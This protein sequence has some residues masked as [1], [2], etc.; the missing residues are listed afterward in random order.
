MTDDRPWWPSSYDLPAFRVKRRTY[1]QAVGGDWVRGSSV[2]TLPHTALRY[3]STAEVDSDTFSK[4]ILFCRPASHDTVEILW[5]WPTQ[6]PTW[7]EVALVRSSFG[8]PSTPRDGLTVFRA[9]RED[10]ESEIEGSEVLTPPPVVLDRMMPSKLPNGGSGLVPNGRNFYYTLFF[11]TTAIDWVAAMSDSCLLPRDFQHSERMWDCVPPY[12]QWVDDNNS[13]GRGYL[14]KFLS[15]FGFVMDNTREF[16]EGLVDLHQIDKTP[17]PLLK[18]L[19]E[20]YGLPYEG[21]IGDIR[22]R[23]LVANA[24]NAQHTR[25]TAVGL[26]QVI[27]AVSKYQTEITGSRTL[28]MFPDDSDFYHSTGNWGGLHPDAVAPVLEQEAALTSL[29]WGKI[30]VARVSPDPGDPDSP[31]AVG[32]GMMRVYTAKADELSDLLVAVGDSRIRED[33]DTVLDPDED[34]VPAPTTEY[35]DAPPVSAGITVAAGVP[36]GFSVWVRAPEKSFTVL[37]CILW[38]GP[39]GNPQEVLDVS[40]GSYLGATEVW[41]QYVVQGAPPERTDAVPEARYLIPAIYV[42]RSEA[43]TLVNR[44]AAIDICGAMVYRLGDENSEVAVTPPDRYL[45][46]GDPTERIGASKEDFDGFVL[47]SPKK[48]V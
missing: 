38:V 8:H 29:E 37:P 9:E 48:S 17:M 19:G 22:Y 12:Y 5:G 13:V 36:Y 47:G 27:E 14:Q 16:V 43:H 3:P 34:T 18:G 41:E 28:M 30:F 39:S 35:R 25:G 24:P 46:M 4:A 42:D 20:N 31:P 21:G 32:R 11:R 45:T 33:G 26:Q 15:I 6:H 40:I 2:E 44:S 7:S 1:G 23:G 10:F